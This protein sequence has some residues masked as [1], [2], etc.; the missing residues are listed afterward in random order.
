MKESNDLTLFFRFPSVECSNKDGRS[1]GLAFQWPGAAVESTGTLILGV[2]SLDRDLGFSLTTVP[3]Y[4]GRT[5][6][7]MGSCF[8][9]RQLFLHSVDDPAGSSA[10]C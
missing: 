5:P 7:F 9:L 8:F 1:N 2:F 3:A 6:P 10:D 4:Q